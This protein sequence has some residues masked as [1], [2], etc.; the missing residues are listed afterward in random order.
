MKKKDTLTLEKRLE[1]LSAESRS[2]RQRLASIQKEN[3][4]LRKSLIKKDGLFNSLPVG[5]AVI[6]QGRVQEVNRKALE[7]L[8]CTAAEVLGRDFLDLLHPASRAQVRDFHQRRMEGKPVPNEYEA[9]L[10][11]K[12]G[13][14]IPCDVSVEKILWEGRMAFLATLTGLEGRK[15]RERDM[16]RKGKQDLMFTLAS[17]ILRGLE[18][19][20]HG[21]LVPLR[22]SQ[23]LKG[24]EVRIPRKDLLQM[25]EAAEGLA[26]LTRTLDSLSRERYERGREIV[27]DLKGVVQDTVARVE[28]WLKEKASRDGVAINL[29]TYLRSVSPV[30]GNPE[31]LKEVVAGLIDNAVAAMPVGGDLYLSV[32]ENAGNAYVYVQDSGTGIPEETMRRVTDPFFTTKGAEARGLGLSLAGAVLK[33]HQGDLEVESRRDQGTTV[34]LRIPLAK[35]DPRERGGPTRRTRK[36]LRILVMEEDHMIRELLFQVLFS[37]GYRVLTAEDVPGGLERLKAGAFDLAIL[38]SA[39]GDPQGLKLVRRMRR[40]APA[41]RLALIAGQG[42]EDFS[43][44]LAKDRVD[45]LIRKP[46]DMTWVVNR[47]AEV[48]S[49]GAP[50]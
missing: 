28:A 41:T 30:E 11:T 50:K 19:N 27:F 15:I 6:S 44:L 20:V 38:G 4:Q 32:E 12:A 9:V 16:I 45:L 22:K 8:G 49:R 14:S 37:K 26:S 48:L 25:S 13:Q 35:G 42:E 21:I 2:L 40:M 46:I 1:R 5:L 31:E 3:G 39:P 34:T 10:A 47:I 18:G 29:K 23:P 17:G 7:V 24:P 43:G 36:N 33:R